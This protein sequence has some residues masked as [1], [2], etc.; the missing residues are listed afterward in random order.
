MAVGVLTEFLNELEEDTREDFLNALSEDELFDFISS[1]EEFSVLTKGREPDF[2][3]RKMPDKQSDV[4][5]SEVKRE[6]IQER[7]DQFMNAFPQRK[8]L[9]A[10]K[11]HARDLTQPPQVSVSITLNMM[12]EKAGL[13]KP[14]AKD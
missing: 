4:T 10:L 11:E 8:D 13:E 6:D 14:N 12:R 7:F 1:K 3:L 5:F 9:G 2:T